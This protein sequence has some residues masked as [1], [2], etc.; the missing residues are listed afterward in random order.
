[1]TET[2]QIGGVD[3]FETMAAQRLQPYLRDARKLL[4]ICGLAGIDHI[5]P[6]TSLLLQTDIANYLEDISISLE[7]SAQIAGAPP[8]RSSRTWRVD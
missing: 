3:Q 1:M 8:P 7:A 4:K 5:V 6:I 2:L